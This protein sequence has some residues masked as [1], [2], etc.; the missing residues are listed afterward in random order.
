MSSTSRF[1]NNRLVLS[2]WVVLDFNKSNHFILVPT[3][4]HNSFLMDYC[5][6]INAMQ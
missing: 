4:M 5:I 6:I 2:V 1:N 3:F